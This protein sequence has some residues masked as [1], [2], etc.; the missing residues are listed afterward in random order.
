MAALGR[1]RIS[2]CTNSTVPGTTT[3]CGPASARGAGRSASGRSSLPQKTLVVVQAAL[4]LVLL[5]GAGLM[6]QT[7]RN[8]TS[9]QFGFQMEGSVVANVNAGFGGYAPEKLAAFMHSHPSLGE[10]ESE[11][12]LLALDVR[13]QR[14]AAVC[15][16]D[17]RAARR[18]ARDLDLPVKGTLGVLRRL[19]GSG[20]IGH[21]DLTRLRGR[22]R[23]SGFRA[24]ASLLS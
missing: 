8:L 4:S 12:I 14:K 19:Q 24:D 7:L 1:G 6:V 9:Q 10:G 13:S 2:A 17:E 23:A 15:I 22:L 18:I 16:I 5:T 20:L 3:S 11:V 21:E